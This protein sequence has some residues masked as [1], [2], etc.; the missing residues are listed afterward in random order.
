[1]IYRV[2]KLSLTTFVGV[3]VGFFVN[4]L[5]GVWDFPPLAS[6][7]C[8]VFGIVTIIVV[9]FQED[10]PRAFKRVRYR[11]RT[12]H[13]PVVVFDI[14]QWERTEYDIDQWER[15]DRRYRDYDAY[16]RRTKARWWQFWIV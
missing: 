3:L 12:R 8:I 10:V 6:A 9:N 7:A 14:E 1:M 2:A 4:E 13:E 11:F 16:V 15:E 5:E